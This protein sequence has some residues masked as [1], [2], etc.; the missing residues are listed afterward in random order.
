[1]RTKKG[2]NN[3]MGQLDNLKRH[4]DD[5]T[6]N[7]SRLFFQFDNLR[8][9]ENLFSIWQ[10]SQIVKQ[11]NCLFSFLIWLF[12]TIWQIF[13]NLTKESNHQI[14]KLKR[15]NFNLTI[16]NL[17]FFFNFFFKFVNSQLQ[18]WQI[19]KRDNFFFK[20]VKLSITKLSNWKNCQIDKLSLFS[21]WQIWQFHFLTFFDIFIFSNLTICQFDNLT[22]WQF[23]KSISW[24][25][26]FFSNQNNFSNQNKFVK[27]TIWQWS[28]WQFEN[29]S[30]RQFFKS[31]FSIRLQTKKFDKLTNCHI[32]KLKICLID[33]FV[34]CQFVKSTS[35]VNCLSTCQ[36]CQL[37]KFV[38]LLIWQI[39]KSPICQIWQIDWN[40]FSQ[41]WLID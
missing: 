14:V 20:F 23:V 25:N 18:K 6:I 37:V 36:V 10:K 3:L 26:R 24:Q 22:S 32:D 11:S 1:M 5:F 27:S 2:F 39:A 16:I 4:F 21:I 9:F 13:F 15:D 34:N 8:Q 35:V 31:K 33:K 38:N 29:L 7:S 19:E 28:I 40:N 12:E 30:I 17:K 41:I